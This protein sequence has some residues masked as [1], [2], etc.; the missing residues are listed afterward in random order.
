MQLT[1]LRNDTMVRLPLPAKVNGQ[2]W[3]TCTDGDGC[4]SQL[5]SVEGVGSSWVLKSNK[6]AWVLDGEKQRVRELV[7]ETNKFYE[8]VV[9]STKERVLLHCEPSTDDRKRYAKYAVPAEARLRIGRA[10]GCDIRFESSFVSANHA[11]IVFDGDS[12]SIT[13]TE[14]ANGTFVNSRRVTTDTLQPGDVISLFGLA[15]VV[16][17]AFLAIN[18]PD[19]LVTLNS[20]RLAPLPP[21]VPRSTGDGFEVEE[22]QCGVVFYR[23]PRFKRDIAT[24]EITIDPPPQLNDRDD[25]PLVM[26]LGPALTMGIA[27][28]FMGIFA[29]FNVVSTGGRIAQA[30]PTL[31]MSVSMMVG[32]ILWPILARRHER[33]QKAEREAKRQTKYRAYI[34][35]MSAKIKAE[36]RSQSEILFENLVTVDDCV[37]RIR[38]RER[39][40]WERTT[41]HDD[42]LL[43]RLGMGT[44]VFDA[45]IK[46]ASAQV[47]SR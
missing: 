12:I 32:M 18:N 23:S 47:H 11:E 44:G 27:S 19:G 7:L 36:R 46:H 16:G 2:F 17:R 35:E 1:L 29:V 25:M 34:D 15:I 3:V 4:E 39:G 43:V 26:V 37:R 22:G 13:D 41:S 8:V 14:S 30:L 21:Q 24:A 40:L 6:R 9:D 28:L 20:A 10:E 42:F 45:Q 5:I 38:A 33:I 31:I